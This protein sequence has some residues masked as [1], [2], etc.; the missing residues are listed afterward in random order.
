MSVPAPGP[1]RLLAVLDAQ[2]RKT[3]QEAFGAAGDRARLDMLALLLG[4]R[5][6]QAISTDGAAVRL[7]IRVATPSWTGGP[8]PHLPASE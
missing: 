1:W 4:S 2:E 8:G 5:S 3:T 6:K 7:T